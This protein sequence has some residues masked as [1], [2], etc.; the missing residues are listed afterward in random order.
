[1][2]ADANIT[3]PFGS[4]N[5]GD[6]SKSSFEVNELFFAILRAV[7]NVGAH[8]STGRKQGVS[9]HFV[10]CVALFFFNVS[11]QLFFL[12]LASLDAGNGFVIQGQSCLR[13]VQESE[14]YIRFQE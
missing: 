1:M 5:L 10:Y 9:I 4:K 2:S 14:E 3:V 11:N 7:E 12:F 13:E 6:L 8:K